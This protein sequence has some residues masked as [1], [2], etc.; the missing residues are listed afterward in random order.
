VQRRV[1]PSLN[2]A[3]GTHRLRSHCLLVVYLL[4]ASVA[5]YTSLEEEEKGDLA[6][7]A[8]LGPQ[9]ALPQSAVD[10]A[11]GLNMGERNG[12]CSLCTVGGESP[13]AGKDTTVCCASE[14]RGE[15]D[16]DLG[17]AIIADVTEGDGLE[18]DTVLD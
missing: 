13:K 4:A 15:E 5:V 14:K 17:P 2:A 6:R 16:D 12:L 11:N 10:E 8:A 9:T 7:Q 3:K 18:Y 1:L